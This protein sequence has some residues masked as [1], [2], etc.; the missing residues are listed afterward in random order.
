MKIL[1]INTYDIR[2]GAARACYRLH[3]ALLNAGIDSQM[4]VQY[5][6]SDDDTVIIA[7]S[8]VAI[9]KIMG[10]IRYALDIFPTKLYRNK[11]PI[12]FS[13]SWLPSKNIINKINQINP[14]LVHLHWICNGMIR[15]ED[16]ASINIPMVWSLH[17]MWAFTGGCHYTEECQR[18]KENCGNCKVLKS[19]KDQDFSNRI[20]KRKEKTYNKINHM[21]I[22]S[23]SHWLNSCSKNSPLLRNKQNFNFPNLI[24]TNDFIPLDKKKSREFCNLPQDKKLILFDATRNIRK[25][26]KELSN[27]LKMLD[28][29]NSIEFVVFGS[30]KPHKVPDFGFKTNYLGTLKDNKKLVALY[31]AVDLIVVPSLQENLSN[32]I[33][34]SLACATPVVAFDI[35]GNGDMIVH[36]ENG[37]LAKPFEDEDLKN[38]IEWILSIPNY[39]ELCQNARNKIVKE[40]DSVVVAKRYVDLYRKVIKSNHKETLKS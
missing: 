33:M 19:S 12:L 22:I 11:T 5:K 20:F 36:K 1:I 25:G 26:F 38:G 40:F 4:L 10:I 37:Y 32:T 2:G 34:E 8:T 35:G 18:Y 16:L 7:N 30:S 29:D 31:S 6:E 39:E 13:S 27:A 24:N 28:K 17:D 9:G 23:L 15:I 21:T 3:R 14:D